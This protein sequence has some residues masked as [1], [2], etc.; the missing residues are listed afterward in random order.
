MAQEKSSQ[1]VR[2]GIIG[3]GMMGI[4]HML[5]IRIC[6]DA[7]VVAFADPHE[8]S[9]KWGRDT[10]GAAARE[11]ADH[12]DLLA[13]AEVD[14]VIVSTPNF[15]HVDVLADAFQTTKHILAEKPL[16][17]TLEDCLKVE[18][19][20][21]K[22]PAVFWVAMEYRYIPAAARLIE[23][24][25]SGRLGRLRMLAIREHRQPFLKKV[26][27]WN[28]F[29]RNTG[30]TLVE[31]CCHFYDLMR[32]ITRDEPV[33]V[34]GSGGC[35]VNHLDERYDGEMPDIIDNAYTIVDFAGGCRA[36][37]DLCMFAEGSRNHNEIAAVGE[38]GK[39]ECFVPE[40]TVVIGMRDPRSVETHHV[41]VE[42]RILKS[43][44]HEGSTYF[45][46]QAFLKAIREGGEP[47]VSVRDGL[48][49]VAMGIAAQRSI[50]EGRPVE[51][52]ELGL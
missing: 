12:R 9:R 23:E 14:A 24:V 39:V 22:H 20:A 35:D 26:G 6:S 10:A 48:L 30:G 47:E 46:H 3:S 21:A 37:L 8:T 41:P 25:H 40:S 38:L 36:I 5:N 29:N 45:E 42:E 51:M 52:R 1:K 34:Y 13:D 18:E 19:A 31:K 2:Y 7:E 27:D 49:A 50:E 32:L 17:T 44:F 16:C 43:G 28:R 15:T 4:E 11:Y 33:R